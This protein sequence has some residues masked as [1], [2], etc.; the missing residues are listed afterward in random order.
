MSNDQPSSRKPGISSTALRTSTASKSITIPERTASQL[1]SEP[2]QGSD[3]AV[4]MGEQA[5]ACL[6]VALEALTKSI[7]CLMRMRD[8]A[9]ELSCFLG[10]KQ[11]VLDAYQREFD[12]TFAEVQEYLTGAECHGR[13]LFS[14]DFSLDAAVVGGRRCE[15]GLQLPRVDLASLGWQNGIDLSKRPAEI[16]LADASVH[17]HPEGIFRRA[18]EHY[19]DDPGTPQPPFSA[20][21]SEATLAGLLNAHLPPHERLTAAAIHDIFDGG[22]A[23]AVHAGLLNEVRTDN[24]IIASLLKAVASLES[25]RSGVFASMRR[26]EQR[27]ASDQAAADVPVRDLSDADLA[28]RLYGS[29]LENAALSMLMQTTN[30]EDAKRIRELLR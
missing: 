26:L 23:P 19:L 6:N 1:K 30:A 14:G 18:L 22:F 4:Q 28:K 15:I 11:L 9:A 8:C 7:N 5:A 27:Q 13:K 25:I 24:Q 16:P 2:R 12:V 21:T 10:E 17:R 20:D 3:A 29:P